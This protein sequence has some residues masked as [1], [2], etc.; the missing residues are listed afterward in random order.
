M[1]TSQAARLQ[2]PV[3]ETN[4]SDLQ[5]VPSPGEEG[6]LDGIGDFVLAHG[7]V[8]VPGAGDPV[9]YTVSVPEKLDSPVVHVIVPGFGGVK[10]SSRGLRNALA[11]LENLVAISF[12]PARG[13]GIVRD[14]LNAQKVHADTLSAILQDLPD[15]EELQ[16]TPNG[17]EL[18]LS[19]AV[20]LPHSMGSLSATERARL[21][22]DETQ[23]V[24]YMGSVGLGP[25]VMLGFIPRLLMSSSQDVAGKYAQGKLVPGANRLDLAYR[26]AR[27]YLLNPRRTVG[28]IGSCF[29][30]DIRKPVRLLDILGVNTA[31]L[32]FDADRLVPTDKSTIAQVEEMVQI[33]EVMEGYGHLAP[34]RHPFEVAARLGSI[35]GRLEHAEQTALAA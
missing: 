6:F 27:Y 19:Q 33:C 17:H 24:I 20:L 4:G 26:A 11:S 1:K 34:Q 25:K 31:A 21:Y 35:S 9:K 7:T 10:R 18:D 8:E 30:A 23:S 14:L 13:G 29:T 15:N 16:E 3:P 12:E 32:Y 5:L 28:E 22:P 2:Q